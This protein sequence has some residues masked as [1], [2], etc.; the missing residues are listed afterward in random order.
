MHRTDIPIVFPAISPNRD[1]PDLDPLLRPARHFK[2][3]GQVL[4]DRRL[5]I[6]QKR[7]ILSSWASDACAVESCPALRRPPGIRSAIAFDD[8]MDALHQLDC[9][10]D[11]PE[12]A[13]DVRGEAPS[14]RL[15]G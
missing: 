9:L 8:I 15:N 10:P 14:R 7:A 11:T 13:V 4:T 2:S 5:S 12:T 3:P 1:D 6:V